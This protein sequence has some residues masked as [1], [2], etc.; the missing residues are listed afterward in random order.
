MTTLEH[1][2]TN[3]RRYYGSF[4]WKSGDH[5]WSVSDEGGRG[6]EKRPTEDEAKAI[7]RRVAMIGRR[8]TSR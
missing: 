5:E 4:I 6:L 2:P 1:P 8:Q 7:A 3:A